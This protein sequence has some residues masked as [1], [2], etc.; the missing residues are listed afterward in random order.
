MAVASVTTIALV[1]GRPGRVA[2]PV[3]TIEVKPQLQRVERELGRVSAEQRTRADRIE[4]AAI[5]RDLDAMTDRLEVAAEAVV[6]ATSDRERA[7]AKIA[8]ANLQH[9]IHDRAQREQDRSDELR[10]RLGD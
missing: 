10:S 8:L 5:E 1:V 3:A 9:E 4:L 7:D 6:E 2:S